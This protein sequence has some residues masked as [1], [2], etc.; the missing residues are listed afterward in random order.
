MTFVSSHEMHLAFGGF[1]KVKDPNVF[2][3]DICHC[4]LAEFEDHCNPYYMS[5]VAK[6][7]IMALSEGCFIP[8]QG[9]KV[10]SMVLESEIDFELLVAYFEVEKTKARINFLIYISNYFWF[11]SVS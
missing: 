7:A 11:V 4:S 8:W 5:V 10:L 6:L 1:R 9:K 3:F 2:T